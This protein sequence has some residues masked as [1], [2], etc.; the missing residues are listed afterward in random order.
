MS[1]NV[2]EIRSFLRIMNQ[3][4]K[5][6]PDLATKTKGLG[7]DIFSTIG[8]LGNEGLH[9]RK[10]MKIS[11]HRTEDSIL[12]LYD[13]NRETKI[14]ADASSYGLA[15]AVYQFQDDSSWKPYAYFQ[16]P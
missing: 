14:L 8:L 5:F 13:C 6:A 2:A 3:Q 7:Q 11:E 16:R 9:N 1:K 12:A 10:S 4:S 15:E